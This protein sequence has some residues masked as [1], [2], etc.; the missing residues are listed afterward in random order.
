MTPRERFVHFVGV[1]APEVHRMALL[2]EAVR[3]D[4]RILEAEGIDDQGDQIPPVIQRPM[5]AAWEFVE[6]RRY[7]VPR[8]LWFPRIINPDLMP[9][10]QR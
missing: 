7:G 4:P 9:I 2:E 10:L 8:P 1:F 6:Y 5:D 3:M